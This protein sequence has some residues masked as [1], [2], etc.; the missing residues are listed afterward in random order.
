MK[1][2]WIF[3]WWL[4]YGLNWIINKQLL[5]LIQFSVGHK[6]HQMKPSGTT[7]EN[8]RTKCPK[9]NNTNFTKPI[10][11]GTAPVAVWKIKSPTSHKIGKLYYD[12]ITRLC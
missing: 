9:H 11:S 1:I 10:N 2:H 12:N 3:N 7:L 4:H 5:K 6:M 8:M